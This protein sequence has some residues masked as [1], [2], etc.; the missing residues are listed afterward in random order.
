VQEA[1]LA[2]ATQWPDVGVLDDPRA[3][4]VRV[5]ARRAVDHVRGEASR[6]QRDAAVSNLESPDARVALAPDDAGAGAWP[7]SV[8]EDEPSTS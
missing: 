2:A 8:P 6:R 7:A 3:W 5:A 1:L 4:L